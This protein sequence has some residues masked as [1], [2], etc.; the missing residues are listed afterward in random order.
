MDQGD[1]EP[2]HDPP[3]PRRPTIHYGKASMKIPM[4]TPEPTEDEEEVEWLPE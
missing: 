2:L 3:G 1:A 4:G